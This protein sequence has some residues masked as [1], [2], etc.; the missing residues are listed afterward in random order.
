[1]NGVGVDERL[2]YYEYNSAG[3]EINKE[4]Y[5][6]DWQGSVIAT[7]DGTGN[8]VELMSYDAFGNPSDGTGQPFKYTGRCQDYDTGLMDYR[9]RAYSPEL[10]RF[11]QPDPIGYAGG[12][13][14]YAYVG[15]D[16]INLVDPSGL[17]CGYITGGKSGGIIL[18]CNDYS[19]WI[20]I[21]CNATPDACRMGKGDSWILDT[22]AKR[23]PGA[24]GGKKGKKG[25][26]DKFK[27]ECPENPFL[28]GIGADFDL[29]IFGFGNGYSFGIAA[30]NE[31][32]LYFYQT[33][34]N[35]DG[36][37][38]LGAS[39]EGIMGWRDDINGVSNFVEGG[40]GYAI[41]YGYDDS[42][43]FSYATIQS[44]VEFGFSYG[45]SNTFVSACF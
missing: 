20:D 17:Q 3:E 1:M 4:Y 14:I 40:S 12:M 32:N 21:D 13:N 8:R 34:D 19:D 33:D 31:D 42:G 38:A 7:S 43:E 16:P 6:V 30:D 25:K 5:H 18:P 44:G 2:A 24:G 27:K 22:D 29:N 45:K 36:G 35:Y 26:K 37:L 23:D 11:L 28:V 39:F 15:N 10:G 41:E 9:A